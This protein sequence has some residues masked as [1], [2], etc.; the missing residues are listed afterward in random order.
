MTNDFGPC[1]GFV[2]R[3]PA[4]ATLIVRDLLGKSKSR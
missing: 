4:A 3:C 1:F 2:K